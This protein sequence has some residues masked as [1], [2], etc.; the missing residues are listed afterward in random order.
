[1]CRRERWRSA[2][3][4]RSS[5]KAGRRD[6]KLRYWRARSTRTHPIN[7]CLDRALSYVETDCDFR[8]LLAPSKPGRGILPGYTCREPEV[9]IMLRQV[10]LRTSG[11]K[12]GTRV[13][14]LLVSL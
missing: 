1:M 8:R 4:S 3:A 12:S 13:I 2:A 9:R 14:E 5:R 6:S 7:H 11:S 10:R